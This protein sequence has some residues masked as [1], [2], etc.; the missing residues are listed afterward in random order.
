MAIP[1]FEVQ[2]DKACSV[3]QPQQE[4]DILH[5]LSTAPGDQTTD[6]VALS[7]GFEQG[8]ADR[9]PSQEVVADESSSVEPLVVTGEASDPGGQPDRIGRPSENCW[10]SGTKAH[11]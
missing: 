7:H 6:I 4:A 10:I 3:F 8:Q 11:W 9:N 5:F 1:I 2:F